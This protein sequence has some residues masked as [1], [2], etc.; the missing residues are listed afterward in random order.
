MRAP[1]RDLE[2]TRTGTGMGLGLG[3]ISDLGNSDSTSLVI[4]PSSDS[5]ERERTQDPGIDNEGVGRYS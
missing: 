3:L 2:S 4:G 5:V 1:T